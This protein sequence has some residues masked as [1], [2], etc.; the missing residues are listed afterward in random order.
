[1][2]Y[3]VARFRPQEAKPLV[4]GPFT[5]ERQAEEAAELLL[6]ASVRGRLGP[7][8]ALARL[9][10]G[11][12]GVILLTAEDRKQ[13]KSRVRE[14]LARQRRLHRREPRERAVGEDR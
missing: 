9:E 2:A 10:R 8:A 14:Q 13:A 3:F 6:G 11:Q 4:V 5:T 7:A 1:M 12:P